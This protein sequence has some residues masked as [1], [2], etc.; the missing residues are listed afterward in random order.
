MLDKKREKILKELSTNKINNSN[1]SIDEEQIKRI[2]KFGDLNPIVLDFIINYQIHFSDYNEVLFNNLEKLHIYMGRT[3][4]EEITGYYKNNKI[5]ILV[6]N[7]Q[8][9]SKD[10]IDLTNF[11]V[12]ELLHAASY[13]KKVNNYS[14]GF[15]KRIKGVELGRRLNAGYTEYLCKNYFTGS[16]YFDCYYEDMKLAE[17]VESLIGKDEMIKSYFTGDLYNVLDKLNNYVDNSL[18]F[19]INSEDNIKEANKILGNA[20]KETKVKKLKR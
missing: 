2:L 20:I 3:P 1:I 5:D 18:E 13:D 15:N 6:P 11:L 19:I 12:Y 4:E 17:K 10:N 9:I 7:K 14:T 16:H 8:T